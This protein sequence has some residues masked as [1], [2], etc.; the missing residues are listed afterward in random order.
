MDGPRPS[1]LFGDVEVSALEFGSPSFADPVAII[2]Q[3]RRGS[4]RCHAVD[5]PDRQP[6]QG[7][8]GCHRPIAPGK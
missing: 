6:P 5:A 8:T 7:C 1:T 3:G 4:Q 2:R